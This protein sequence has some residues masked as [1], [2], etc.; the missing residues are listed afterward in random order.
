MGRFMDQRTGGGRRNVFRIGLIFCLLKIEATGSGGIVVLPA[1]VRQRAIDYP[2]DVAL[3][4]AISPAVQVFDQLERS[5]NCAAEQGVVL[6][7]CQNDAV[8][9]S[10][11]AAALQTQKVAIEQRFNRFGEEHALQSNEK[12][13]RDSEWNER[14]RYD[15]DYTVCGAKAKERGR[16]SQSLSEFAVSIG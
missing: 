2:F 16:M 5:R 3:D 1:S 15:I 8:K 14:A 13:I 6:C 12:E 11:F 4:S 9:T 7:V 10:D